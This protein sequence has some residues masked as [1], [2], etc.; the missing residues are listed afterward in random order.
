MNIPAQN[1]RVEILMKMRKQQL[2][3]TL[4]K[5]I[6]LNNWD[7]VQLTLEQYKC[8]QENVNGNFTRTEQEEEEEEEEKDNLLLLDTPLILLP[9]SIGWAAIHFTVL[10]CSSATETNRWWK[11]MIL[12]VL[13]D[14][15]NY[16]YGRSSS[17]SSGNDNDNDNIKAET[18]WSPF[19]HR[20]EAGYSSIDLFFAKRLFPFPFETNSVKEDASRL[21]NTIKKLVLHVQVQCAS[22]VSAASVCTSTDRARSSTAEEEAVVNTYD[23]DNV[24][25]SDCRNQHHALKTASSH[26]KIGKED[27]EE[28]TLYKVQRQQQQ[29]ECSIIQDLRQRIRNKIKNERI[30]EKGTNDGRKCCS[31]STDFYCSSSNS[32]QNQ[33][34][35]TRSSNSVSEIRQQQYYDNEVEEVM[36]SSQHFT[37]STQYSN[38][39]LEQQQHQQSALGLSEEEIEEVVHFWYDMEILVMAAVHDT[40]HIDIT[41]NSDIVTVAPPSP[42]SISANH[43]GN[44]NKIIK[45]WLVVHALAI[46]GCP[47]EVAKLAVSLY[48]EQIEERDENGN[49]PLH[50]ACSSHSAGSFAEGSGLSNNNNNN[51]NSAQQRS[52]YN[53][54]VLNNNKKGQSSN[55]K[56]K[57]SSSSSSSP[58]LKCLLDVYPQATTL[59]NSS[60]KLPMTLALCAGK[61]WYTGI[62]DI[63]Q[64]NPLMLLSGQSRDAETKLHAFMVAAA[65]ADFASSTNL[66]PGALIQVPSSTSEEMR[67]AQRIASKKIGSMWRFLPNVSKR[68]AIDTARTELEMMK[69]TTI[70]E[71]LRI[72]PDACLVQRRTK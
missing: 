14:N 57:C 8:L 5:Q 67:M 55:K 27:L 23:G 70:F 68:K 38:Q 47:T 65:A 25:S 53:R 60:Q 71:L 18:T 9:N 37:E 66:T 59:P 52:D 72:V 26:F 20:T 13:E 3:S 48:H 21:L 2:L 64:S 34:L 56:H 63:F 19:L 35:D 50:L 46:T 1:G 6:R 11:W 29:C 24:D 41:E 15:H 42:T 49:L 17:S 54:T 36:S 58:M 12:R 10:H 44:K 43:A 28:Q 22:S 61:Y 30:T 39:Y 51:G 62:Q 33:D 40:I 4:H 45:K 32:I 16:H 31:N 69:L 7:E